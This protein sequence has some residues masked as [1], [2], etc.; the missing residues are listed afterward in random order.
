MSTGSLLVVDDEP[1]YRKLLSERHGRNGW[2]V[3]PT[4]TG[5]EALRIA[6]K[7]SIDVALIDILMPGMN[8][9][10]LLE[11]LKSIDPAIEVV[12]LTGHA[13]VETAIRAMKL[14]AFDYLSKPY[15]LSELDVVV[16]R[17]AERRRLAHR[18]VGLA[19]QVKHLEGP[20]DPMVGQSAA[21]LATVRLARK[22]AAQTLPV[23]I[24]GESGTGKEVIASAL[25]RWSGRAAEVLVPIDCGALPE[26]LLESEL[27]GH[28]RGAFTGAVADKEGLFQVASAGTLFLDEIGELPLAHQAKL[29]RV[30]ETGEFR[31]IGQTALRRTDARVIAATNRDLDAA[32]AA[33]QFREDLLYRLNVVTIAVPPL[34][35]RA[36]DVPLLVAHFMAR[37]KTGACDLEPGGMAR[38][39][40]YTWPGNVRELRNV[41]ERLLMLAE[42]PV[43]TERLVASLL[44]E[45]G[46]R[47]RA[48][49]GK[50]AFDRVMPLAD[51]ER[52]YVRWALDEC[53]GNVTTTARRLGISRSTLYRHTAPT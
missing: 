53:G 34:R 19:A 45:R 20:R 5:A 7:A 23:L 33:G 47:P 3:F 43:I 30:L 1:H 42:G 8:G 11:R 9:L 49:G 38:L 26:Q 21:W 25:H 16:E 50:P 36:E 24:T 2:A 28:R 52:S 46:G 32:I 39:T 12:V 37:S 15:K 4:A 13:S 51:M 35:E 41:V 44:V 31:P 17:A 18:C 10:D 6:E 29:L 14:G 27:F 22:A 48:N 40:D